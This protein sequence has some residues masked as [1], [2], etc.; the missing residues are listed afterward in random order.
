[1]RHHR[2]TT[3]HLEEGHRENPTGTGH[4]PSY[5]LYRGDGSEVTLVLHVGAEH[6]EAIRKQLH[7]WEVQPPIVDVIPFEVE[8]T[9]ETLSLRAGTTVYFSK[10]N[11]ATAAMAGPDGRVFR[12]LENGERQF[13]RR[14]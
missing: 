5:N 13:L 7:L 9:G 11:P 8:G 1:M 12:L 4:R 2:P 6:Y 3:S 10:A 14:I